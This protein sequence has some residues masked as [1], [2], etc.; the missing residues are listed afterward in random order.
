MSLSEFVTRFFPKGFK[1]EN[2]IYKKVIVTYEYRYFY[3]PI[4]IE[5]YG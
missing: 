2:E 1:I 4:Q 3:R 5:E